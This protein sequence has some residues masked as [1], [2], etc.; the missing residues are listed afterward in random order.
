MICWLNIRHWKMKVLRKTKNMC[1]LIL[2]TRCSQDLDWCF[3]WISNAYSGLEK[4][5]VWSSCTRGFPSQASNFSCSQW[6]KA[7]ASCLLVKL[8]FRASMQLPQVLQLFFNQSLNK[9]FLFSS[10]P[11]VF[12]CV[13]YINLFPPPQDLKPPKTPYNWGCIRSGLIT[14][15]L[16]C[17]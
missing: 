6:A 11:N 17:N 16:W 8:W 2:L 5:V 7:Q 14:G 4:S 1:K 3:Y 9:S 15:I 10:I 12:F 13:P